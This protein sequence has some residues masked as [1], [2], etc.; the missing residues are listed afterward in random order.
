MKSI[1]PAVIEFANE[2]FYLAFNNRDLKQMSYIWSVDYPSVCIHPG[3]A[4]LIGRE[5]ILQSWE[6]IFAGQSEGTAIVCHGTRVLQQGDLFS[7]ICFEQLSGGWL[8]A[9]NNFIIEAGNARMVHHQASQCMEPPE[10]EQKA[11]TLQ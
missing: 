6:S 9:A 5:D 11:Q 7:V 8:V 10:F 1:D 3:W 2:A 4:P